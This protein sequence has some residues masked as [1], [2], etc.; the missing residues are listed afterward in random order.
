MIF[1]I[2]DYYSLEVLDITHTIKNIFISYNILLINMYKYN[3]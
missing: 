1:G 3:I 2:I